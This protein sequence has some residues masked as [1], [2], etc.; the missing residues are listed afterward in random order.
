MAAKKPAAKLNKFAGRV[1]ERAAE[2]VRRTKGTGKTIGVTLRFGPD[3]WHAL[4]RYALDKRTSIQRI[5][6]QGCSMV[7]AKDGQPPLK[8]APLTKAS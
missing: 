4:S 7:L 5:A 8:A 3:D 2:A 1:A 6:L